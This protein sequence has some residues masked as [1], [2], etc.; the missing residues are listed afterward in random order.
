MFNTN[1]NKCE[2]LTEQVLLSFTQP[3]YP[4]SRY[5]GVVIDS[6]LSWSQHIKEISNKANR[7]KS[8]LQR[9][10]HYCPPSIKANSY[11]S[12]IKPILEYAGVVWAP[13]TNKDISFIESVQRCAARFVF[14]NYSTTSH[15]KFKTKMCM[16]PLP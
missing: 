13:H 16:K 5:L 15:S 14:N 6:K 10:L 3:N 8:F 4:W 7:V 11:T 12:L 2:F 9:N 1:I